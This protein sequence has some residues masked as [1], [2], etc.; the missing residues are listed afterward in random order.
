MIAVK[1]SKRVSGFQGLGLQGFR[2]SG[3]SGFRVP[4]LG[5]RVSSGVKINA[6]KP[7]TFA[8]NI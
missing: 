1:E 4:A 2:L 8:F 5:L 7:R 6:P 3:F